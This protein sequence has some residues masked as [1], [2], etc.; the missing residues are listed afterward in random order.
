MTKSRGIHLI[1]LIY[2]NIADDVLHVACLHYK[3]KIQTLKS[4]PF[5]R[6]IKFS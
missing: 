4:K 3:K 5:P 1:C 2:V 6:E